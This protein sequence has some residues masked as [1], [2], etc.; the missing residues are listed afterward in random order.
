MKLTGN[1]WK[2]GDNISATD[3]VSAKYD[4]DG[5]SQKW[6]E[7]AK[8]VLEEIDP[9]FPAVIRKGDILVAGANFGAG[10]AHYYMTAIMGCKH[11]G[12]SSL[13]AESLNGLFQRAAIDGGVPAW[14]FKGLGELVQSGDR[15]EFDLQTGA[16]HNL[17]S[18]ERAQF[19]P[20][21]R[22]VLDILEAGGSTNWALQRVGASSPVH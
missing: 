3:I 2:L 5:M 13:L 9:K 22:I 20:V 11:A 12:F 6:D 21:S 7:C 19:K 10:H 8:H 16:A 15:L 14:S 17:T 1:V 18:G 4:K